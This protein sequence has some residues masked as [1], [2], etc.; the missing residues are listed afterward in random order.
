MRARNVKCNRKSFS[1]FQNGTQGRTCKETVTSF[2]DLL[3]LKM[4]ALWS[5]EMERTAHPKAQFYF[6]ADFLYSAAPLW[7]SQISQQKHTSRRNTLRM[8]SCVCVKLQIS[9]Y[10]LTRDYPGLS[11]AGRYAPSVVGKSKSLK[12]ILLSRAGT[13][14]YTSISERFFIRNK[15]YWHLAMFLSGNRSS[16]LQF[17][18]LRLKYK[19]KWKENGY[20]V[21]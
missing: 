17:H 14:A 11:H 1:S 13:A 4:K 9:H 10:R 8:R 3:T 12:A 19:V 16:A 15:E 2:F 20:D 21:I 6:R 18:S 7:E 5:F